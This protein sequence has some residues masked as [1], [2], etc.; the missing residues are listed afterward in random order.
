MCPRSCASG[1]AEMSWRWVV[2]SWFSRCGSIYTMD[3]PVAPGVSAMP[4]S[5]RVNGAL[6]CREKVRLPCSTRLRERLF[7]SSL[8]RRCWEQFVSIRST[9]AERVCTAKRGMRRRGFRERDHVGA[10]PSKGSKYHQY[11]QT[12][13]VQQHIHRHKYN[14]IDSIKLQTNKAPTPSR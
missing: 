5:G 13:G 10:W 7:Y 8:Q 2:R 11:K 6:A 12:I 3:I 9:S 1:V 14:K 4:L